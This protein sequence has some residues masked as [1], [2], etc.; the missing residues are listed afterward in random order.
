MKKILLF[1]SLSLAYNSYSQGI[2]N[3]GAN[4]VM[5]AGTHIYIDGG[6]S[7]NYT[8]TGASFLKATG[9][10]TTLSLEGNFTNNSSTTAINGI[11]FS[12]IR[13][14]GATQS[15]NGSAVSTLGSVESAGTGAKTISTKQNISNLTLNGQ[16]VTLSDSVNLRGVLTLTSGTLTTNGRLTF[17]STAD[18]T[19]MVAQITSGTITGNVICQR[20]IPGGVGKRK[21]RF[22]TSPVNVSGTY[23]LS[24]FQDDIFV[25][26]PAGAGGGFDV[27][28]FA[29]NASI[30]S[31]TESVA[32]AVANGWTNPTNITN[33]F[34]P[35]IGLEVFVR[36]S[37]ALAN[38]Y[39]N[40]TVPDNVTIDFIGALN[41]GS[42]NV[43]LSFTNNSQPTA[44]GFNLVGNPF[45]C[46]I[47]W[48]SANITRTNMQN[49]MWVYDP[50]LATYGTISSTGTKAGNLNITR[51]VAPGQ[52]FLVR[53]TSSGASISFTESAKALETPFNFFRN[54]ESQSD[55]PVLGIYVNYLADSLST[56]MCLIEF[57]PESTM[58]GNDPYDAPKFFNDKINLYTISD[59]LQALTINS[60]RRPEVRDTIRL[61]FW[62]YDTTNIRVGAHRLRFDSVAN[63]SPL[64][65]VYLKD[66]YTGN[67]I[68]IRNQNT[69]DFN[70]ESDVNSHGNNRFKIIFDL[71]TGIS[72]EQ[73]SKSLSIFPNPANKE[74][75]IKLLDP[76]L[77]KSNGSIRITNLVG[78]EIM[79]LKG[80]EMNE[81]LKLDISSLTNGVYIISVEVDGNV[82]HKKFVKN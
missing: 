80:V 31:Y 23:A 15:L 47:D 81:L 64:L 52:A 77:S 12:L 2:V 34:A 35:G 70:L 43:N 37:R 5:T 57:N 68:N 32:G 10:L 36:G 11:P 72:N 7:G 6:S 19:A 69:Y 54:T 38:P 74:L 67:I 44:D 30:R 56:D 82:T 16:G 18:S 25:T 41:T 71:A 20:F 46:A 17:I 49:F 1:A 45:Q 50:V 42:V 26:A 79:M 73:L 55:I 3:A 27:N 22:L 59:D 62:H 21:W 61:A 8:A 28:P 65:N 40:W 13:L 75:H 66:D 76:E 29:S 9:G 33:T 63:V 4:I 60:I 39:L 53:A 78:A 51:Y 24:Q 58:N 14:V 48:Q